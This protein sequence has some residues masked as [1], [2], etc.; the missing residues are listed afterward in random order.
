MYFYA[1]ISF[2]FPIAFADTIQLI[3][4]ISL[5]LEIYMQ[6]DSNLGQVYLHHLGLYKD[7]LLTIL[8]FYQIYPL[9]I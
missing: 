3:H 5:P 1:L 6:D 9:Y 8:N 7:Y 2:Y 4:N